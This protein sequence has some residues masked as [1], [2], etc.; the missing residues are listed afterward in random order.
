MSWIEIKLNIPHEK[1]EDVSAYIFAQ[2]CEGI[3]IAEDNVLVYFSQFRWSNETKLAL[4]AYIKDFI[5]SFGAKDIQILRVADQDWNKKWK[6]YFKPLRIGK[7]IVVRPTWETTKEMRDDIT[8]TIDP[9]MAF[10]TGHHESTQLMIIALEKWI[11]EGMDI[12]DVG[13]GSGILAIIASKLGAGSVMAF[14]NDA[15]AL[16]NAIDNAHLNG[17]QNS[18]QF[19]MASPEMLQPS[20]YDIILAN[21]NR[22][23]LLKYAQVFPELLK[24]GGKL[25]L[26]G[27]LLRDEP[28]MLQA[29]RDLGFNLVEKNAIKDWLMLVLE[30]KNKPQ[31]PQRNHRDH[32][33]YIQN[34]SS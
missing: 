19:F 3:N 15:V 34:I 28:K 33:E 8:L 20:E 6:E 30:Q 21:I 25:I 12:L 14:D 2:G 27:L 1:M 32:E 31:S 9:Q 17:V 18:V 4:I 23:T 13:T 24:P 10:G 29:F 16:K 22:N 7:R 26:S 5:P 11:K